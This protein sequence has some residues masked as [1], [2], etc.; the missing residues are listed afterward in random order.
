MVSLILAAAYRQ[1]GD[2]VT[3]QQVLADAQMRP[4]KDSP[5]AVLLVQ[6]QLHM[7]QGRLREAAWLY[8]RI[9]RMAEKQTQTLDSVSTVRLNLGQLLYEWNEL[10]EAERL[11][12][13]ALD[14]FREN[15]R[16][17]QQIVAGVH[18]ARLQIA[19]GDPTAAQQTFQ[20]AA[21]KVSQWGA[22]EATEQMAAVAAR[23]ALR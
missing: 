21:E 9:L 17:I 15:E 3:A 14:A 2:A 7:A 18:L 1:R 23:L 8:R 12:G 19:Q 11:L 6:A 5:L 4:Q 16:D 13:S 22:G 10:D 20:V